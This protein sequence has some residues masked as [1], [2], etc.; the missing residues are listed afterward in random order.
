MAIDPKELTR[1]PETA[2]SSRIKYIRL[3]DDDQI[4]EF[5][6]HLLV[7]SIEAKET[8][9]WEKVSRYIE[10]WEDKIG[11]NLA[12]GRQVYETGPWTPLSKPLSQCKVAIV[13]TGGVYVDGDKP[14][15]V[16]GDWSFRVLPR[17]TARERFRIAHE[18]YDLTGVLEDINT[19]FPVDTLK[20][21]EAS[22]A[23][24]CLAET[25]YAFMGFIPQ[26]EGLIGETAPEVARRLK[27]DGVDA[28]VIPTT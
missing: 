25:N 19:V 4:V 6:N 23:I 7:T 5:F 16:T 11:D 10:E 20:E 9:Q 14:F 22:G 3:L 1:I 18:K 28:V 8:G 26:P 27:A 15:D 13:T 2:A 21:L 17:G 12:A 24:G